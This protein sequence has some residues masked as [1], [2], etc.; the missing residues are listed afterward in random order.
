MVEEQALVRQ[1]LA[2]LIERCGALN[3]L[4]A[5]ASLRE[6]GDRFAHLRP[7]V[8]LL[9][10]PAGG[11]D[12]NDVQRI[13]LLWPDARLVVLDERASDTNIRA[14]LRAGA[15]A[16]LTKQQSQEELVEALEQ[17]TRGYRSFAPEVARRLTLTTGGVHLV[18]DASQPLS[19]LTKREIEILTCL[20]QG[21]PVK[22][23]ALLLNISSSTVG[24]HKARIM[25]KLNVHKTVDLVR[26]TIQE[27]LIP[28]RSAE[29]DAEPRA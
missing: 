5:V 13:R 22:K 26:L 6:A 18:D 25:R 29:H 8:L 3:L 12:W 11:Q 1:A 19:S 7:D 27:R 9:S 4:A 10:A 16:Y 23:C 20:A 2:G 28:I 17:V 15:R 21:H 14:A 24:N